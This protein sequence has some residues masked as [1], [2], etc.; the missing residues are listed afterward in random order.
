[1]GPWH[2][3]WHDRTRG[4]RGGKPAE[5]ARAACIRAR[6]YTSQHGATRSAHLHLS[7]L[8]RQP[9]MRALHIATTPLR[10][11]LW[12]RQPLPITTEHRCQG[13]QAATSSSGGARHATGTALVHGAR[14]ATRRAFGRSAHVGALQTYMRSRKTDKV[15]GLEHTWSTWREVESMS[16]D[17]GDMGVRCEACGVQAQINVFDKPRHRHAHVGMRMHAYACA[18]HLEPNSEIHSSP[19]LAARTYREG[20]TLGVWIERS[21]DGAR[22][23]RSSGHGG[24]ERLRH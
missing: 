19:H 23:L 21:R 10:L 5:L 14:R 11:R 12:L 13:R 16:H 6:G 1:M 7:H 8:H 15:G 4:A 9:S 17:G 18:S 22:D 2:G 3:P 24:L 20:E